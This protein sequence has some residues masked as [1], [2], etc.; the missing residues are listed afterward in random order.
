MKV[1]WSKL[2]IVFKNFI[3]YKNV[4]GADIVITYS[5]TVNENAV[6]G[7]SGNANEVELEYSNNPNIVPGGENKPI[8]GDV[9]GRTPKDYVITYIGGVKIYKVDAEGNKLTGAEFELG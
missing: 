5:A 2:E 8:E 9:T 7:N 6:I 1:L 4:A 3:Q